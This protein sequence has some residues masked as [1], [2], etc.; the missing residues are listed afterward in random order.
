LIEESIDLS[1]AGPRVTAKQTRTNHLD[2]VV[3]SII[4]H[5]GR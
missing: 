5:V 1:V 3:A 4:S 2:L